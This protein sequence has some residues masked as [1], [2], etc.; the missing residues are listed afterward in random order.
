MTTSERGHIPDL[1]SFEDD[2]ANISTL[3]V[4]CL[5]SAGSLVELGL[6]VNRKSLA[7]K[8]HVVHHLRRLRK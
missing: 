5:E 6:F 4:I 2:I 3:V 7:Q 8:L 1:M